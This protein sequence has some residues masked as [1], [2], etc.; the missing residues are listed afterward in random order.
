MTTSVTSAHDMSGA[1]LPAHRVLAIWTAT[2]LHTAGR[3]SCHRHR[4]LQPARNFVQAVVRRRRRRST[5]EMERHPVWGHICHGPP[6]I[7]KT[8]TV[9]SMGSPH[10]RHYLPVKRRV[11]VEMQG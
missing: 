5:S 2:D 6:I 3:I 10:H 11:C 1:G 8:F 4:I 7:L 9:A